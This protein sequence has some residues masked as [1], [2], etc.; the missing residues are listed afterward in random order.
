MHVYSDRIAGGAAG[1][2]RD[3]HYAAGKIAGVPGVEF[4]TLG[5]GADG[6]VGGSAC[7]VAVPCSAAKIS[8]GRDV[9]HLEVGAAVGERGDADS[10]SGGATEGGRRTDLLHLPVGKRDARDFRFQV[11]GRDVGTLGPVADI[12]AVRRA[13]VGTAARNVDDGRKNKEQQEDQDKKTTHETSPPDA[14]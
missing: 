12:V 10:F 7:A 3:L 9:D 11:N 6:E 4:R 1:A 13:L 2:G 8:G 5:R 14:A